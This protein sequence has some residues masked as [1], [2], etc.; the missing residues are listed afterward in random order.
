MANRLIKSPFICVLIMMS[1]IPLV[2]MSNFLPVSIPRGLQYVE[3]PPKGVYYEITF[4]K[5]SITGTGDRLQDVP[6]KAICV[7]KTCQ[8]NCC[9]GDINNMLC[10]TVEDCKMYFNSTRKGNIAAAVIIPIAV[11]AIFL[12]AFLLLFMKFKVNGWI[13]AFIAFICMFV[14]TIPFVIWYLWKNKS[15]AITDRVYNE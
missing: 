12:S 11:T 13:S 10:A 1:F 5:N 9:S 8:S 3:Y 14:I 4:L 2:L 15:L 6:Y 7:I